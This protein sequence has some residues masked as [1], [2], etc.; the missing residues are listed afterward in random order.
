MKQRETKK[1]SR[2][3]TFENGSSG[4]LYSFAPLNDTDRSDLIREEEESERK[5]SLTPEAFKE[6]RAESLGVEKKTYIKYR[7]KEKIRLRQ[8]MRIE[9]GLKKNYRRLALK[10]IDSHETLFDL[11]NQTSHFMLE[12]AWNN[13]DSIRRDWLETR[14]ALL[15]KLIN[16]VKQKNENEKVYLFDLIEDNDTKKESVKE[17]FEKSKES[18]SFHIFATI[19]PKYMGDQEAD[20]KVK[21][22]CFCVVT[23]PLEKLTNLNA[24]IPNDI[25]MEPRWKSAYSTNEIKEIHEKNIIKFKQ[26][27]R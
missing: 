20:P 11:I 2:T 16:T 1:Y 4:K 9:T 13:R 6:S 18:P 21:Y 14:I 10:Y 12:A 8:L 7:K 25:L 19:A 26:K 24:G 17:F 22:G 15:V 27:E 5:S 3:S 23:I